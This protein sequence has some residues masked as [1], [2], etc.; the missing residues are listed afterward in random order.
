MGIQFNMALL[1]WYLLI[2]IMVCCLS[3]CVTVTPTLEESR[4]QD[5]HQ[6]EYTDGNSGELTDHSNTG[7][8]NPYK[9][10]GVSPNYHVYNQGLHQGL[11]RYCTPLKAYN[12]GRKGRPYRRVCTNEPSYLYAYEHGLVV[13]RVQNKKDRIDDKLR[14]QEIKRNHI[15]L[16]IKTTQAKLQNKNLP[17]KKRKKLRQKLRSLNKEKRNLTRQIQSKRNRVERLNQ[18]L[19]HLKSQSRYLI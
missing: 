16:K 19:G 15:G 4:H 3:S 7:Y 1:K 18:E 12:L 8:V 9:E 2:L 5:W 14:K 10:Q 11:N 13:H 6:L 17:A